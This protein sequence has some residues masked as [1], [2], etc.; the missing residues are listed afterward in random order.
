VWTSHIVFQ[1]KC[2]GEYDHESY[3]AALY[4]LSSNKQWSTKHHIENTSSSSTNR[5]NNRVEIGYFGRVSNS[6]STS[7]TRRVIIKRHEHHLIWKSIQIALENMN[8]RQ[9]ELYFNNL[10]STFKTK[11]KTTLDS[12]NAEILFRR[13]PLI[14]ECNHS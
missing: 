7:D 11:K 12:G 4:Q 9:K 13:V 8:S 1:M 6:C 2:C 5:T 10:Q 3:F 14:L